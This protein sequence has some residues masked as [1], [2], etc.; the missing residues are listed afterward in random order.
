GR[1][2]ASFKT[3][4][5]V[6]Y[7]EYVQG[8]DRLPVQVST[9]NNP[10][11]MKPARILGDELGSLRFVIDAETVQILQSV[12]Y[13]EFGR[14]ANAIGDGYLPIGYAAGLYDVDTKLVHFGTRDY[15]PETGRFLQKDSVGLSGGDTNLYN[16]VRMEPINEIDP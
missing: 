4:G 14:V 13:D 9:F 10:N 5:P 6:H 8:S 16:Y 7:Y 3:D 11:V 2:M 15:D 1:V 12:E